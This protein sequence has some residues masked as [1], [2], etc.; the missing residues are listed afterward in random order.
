[1]KKDNHCWVT[2]YIFLSGCWDK[3]GNRSEDIRIHYR[4]RSP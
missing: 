3:V 4:G 1:M 2:L